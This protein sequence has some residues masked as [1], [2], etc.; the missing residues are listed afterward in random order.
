MSE[1]TQPLAHFYEG[2]EVYQGLIIKALAPLTVEQ[3]ALRSAPNLRS[4]GELARHMILVRAGWYHFVLG[5]R[6]D[7]FDAVSSWAEPEHPMPSA[8]ELANG[9]SATWQG[10][11]K[12]LARYTPADLAQ[13]VYDE[14]DEGNKIPHTRGWVVWHVIEHDLHHG[15]ELSLTLG[16]HGLAA[17]DL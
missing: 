5:E 10:M 1:T 4:I 16:I 6:D 14:D 3:L 11:Q 8:S 17:P 2:W 7:A 13:I 12:V 9:L 15:G